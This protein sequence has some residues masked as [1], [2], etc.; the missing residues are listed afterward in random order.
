[1]SG[2]KETP[3]SPKHPHRRPTC[4]SLPRSVPGRVTLRVW[5]QTGGVTRGR[6]QRVCRG[7]YPETVI[8]KIVSSRMKNRWESRTEES[9]R[10]HVE[11]FTI[12]LP[13][14][15]GAPCCACPSGYR[16][17]GSTTRDLEGRTCPP[18]HKTPGRGRLQTF[19][20]V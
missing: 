12:S 7:T 13:V 14:L 11:T 4:P 8:S 20:V 6:P 15:R 17:P 3:L 10:V 1:M 2:L 5:R 19:A 9:Y 18:A 16:V